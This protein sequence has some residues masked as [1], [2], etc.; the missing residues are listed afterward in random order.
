VV[1]RPRLSPAPAT[2]HVE[3]APPGA[4][5]TLAGQVLGTSPLTVQ[6]PVARD[7]EL[8]LGKPGYEATRLKVELRA[9][10]QTEVVRELKELQKFGVVLVV[11]NGAATWGYV[12]F[13]GKNLGQNYTM[14]NGP[15]RFTLPV[16]RHQIQ[17]AHPKAPSKLVTID[18][19]ER[20]PTRV[21]VTL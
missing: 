10:E 12:W 4:T 11:V 13:K 6:A 5:V 20:G 16:G 3:T 18:V 2:L 1:L 21:T 14:A 7:A 19:A 17:I 9:G 15:T 8:T